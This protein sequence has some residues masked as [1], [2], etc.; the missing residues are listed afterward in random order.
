MAEND[1]LNLIELE[2]KVK[3]EEEEYPAAGGLLREPTVASR[4]VN[5]AY[6]EDIQVVKKNGGSPRQTLKIIWA[7]LGP[8]SYTH[9]TLPTISSV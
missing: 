5:V 8:V 3:A 2:I 9:L 1:H 7:A 4:T 6:G